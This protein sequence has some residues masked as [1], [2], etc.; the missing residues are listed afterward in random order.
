MRAT[1]Y[2][3]KVGGMPDIRECKHWRQIK[4]IRAIRNLIVRSEGRL[5]SSIDGRHAEITRYIE[6]NPYLSGEA[7]VF[8]EAGYLVRTCHI[9]SFFR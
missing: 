2:L 3:I 1:T 4:N 6:K 9:Q 8:I 7:S 5:P